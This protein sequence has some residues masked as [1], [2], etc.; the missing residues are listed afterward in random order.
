MNGM[1]GGTAKMVNL[2]AVP[3][4]QRSNN[5]FRSRA[6]SG[7]PVRSFMDETGLA[8][9][10]GRE[11]LAYQIEERVQARV[12]HDSADL[13]RRGGGHV[14]VFVANKEASIEVNWPVV[15][16]LLKHAGARFP[17]AAGH[18]ECLH[19]SFRVMRTI[20]EGIDMSAFSG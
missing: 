2:S 9:F 4:S 5:E 17:A 20:V 6:R 7:A 15:R 13:E 10:M 18:G 8:G 16:S 14:G 1:T 12:K 19:G 11:L 3:E